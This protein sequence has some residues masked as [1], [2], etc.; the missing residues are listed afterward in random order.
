MI[1]GIITGQDQYTPLQFSRSRKFSDITVSADG[2]VATIPSTGTYKAILGNVGKST[3]RHQFEIVCTTI[4]GEFKAGIAAH[5]VGGAY[6]WSL[7]EGAGA[8]QSAGHYRSGA[9]YWHLAASNSFE[10]SMGV[11]SATDVIGVT[12]DLTDPALPSIGFYLN[13]SLKKTL[14]AGTST[15]WYPAFSAGYNTIVADAV[16]TIRGTGLAHPVSGFTEWNAS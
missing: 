15:A 1:N 6:N 5:E 13:G 2:M 16:A 9:I 7:G 10:S 12:L 14:I 4:G 11:L 8:L 3:G